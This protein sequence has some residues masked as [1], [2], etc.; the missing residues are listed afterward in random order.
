MPDDKRF[1]GTGC[2][3]P[4]QIDPATGR[5][6]TVSGNQSVKEALYLILM[7]QRTERIT[8]PDFGSDILNYA[9]MDTGTTMLSILRRDITQTIMRQEPRVSDLEVTVELNERR[10]MVLINIDYLVSETNSRDNLVFPFYLDRAEEAIEDTTE[11][12]DT[13][14]INDKQESW[15]EDNE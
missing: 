12:Y 11:D 8:R 6:V 3:F 13:R 9:Y 1:L 7:T 15:L 10:G 4:P 5:F 2:K 14:S